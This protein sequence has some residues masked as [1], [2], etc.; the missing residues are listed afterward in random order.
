MTET[1]KREIWADTLLECLGCY[2]DAFGNR[3]CDYGCP[4]DKCSADWVQRIYH[5][6]LELEEKVE[7]MEQNGR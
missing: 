5:R 3:P 6:K 1:I 4:C 7:R 2:E